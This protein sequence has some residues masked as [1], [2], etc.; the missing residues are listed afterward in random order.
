MSSPVNAQVTGSFISDGNPLMISIPSGYTDFRMINLTDIGSAAAATPVMRAEG[1]SLMAAGSAYYNTK[2]NGAA[3]LDLEITTTTG[4]FTFI[5]DS[6][7]LTIGPSTA[8]NGTEI[9]R[10]APAVASTATTTNLVAGSSVVRLYG[11]TGML[12]VSGWDFTVGTI[13]GSTSFQLKYL[14]NSGFAADATAGT[15]RI[16]NAQDRFYP[17]SRLITAITLATSAVITMSVTHGYTVGQQVRIIVP[18]EFGMTQINGLLGTITAVTSGSTNTI[19]VDIDSSGFTA[20]AYPTS[21]IAASGVSFPQVV[22]VGEAAINSVSQ[23]YGNLLDDAT[24]NVSITGVLVG[25]TV[26]TVEK[27]YQWFANKATSI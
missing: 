19:T 13:V 1:S 8:L 25:A 24:R 14:D 23:P 26:Q 22:P 21:A 4:G 15:F 18:S 6:A 7:L 10:A 9:N 11:T 2:T 3:T 27:R 12:Q 16:I 5:A 17:K 20:F